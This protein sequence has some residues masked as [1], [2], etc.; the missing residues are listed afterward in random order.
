MTSDVTAPSLVSISTSSS[1]IDIDIG[2]TTVTVTARI[3]D[4]LSGLFDGTFE[5]TGSSP[6]QIMFMSP[7]GQIVFGM[8]NVLN[9]VS[10]N[11]LDGSI[12]QR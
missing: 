2:Q 7:S 9:P 10:G 5:R 12:K 4:D 1:V 8:F 3:T 11:R 6:P